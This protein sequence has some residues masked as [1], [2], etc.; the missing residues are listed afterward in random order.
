VNLSLSRIT[1]RDTL[2]ERGDEQTS[3]TGRPADLDIEQRVLAV[4]LTVYG[5]VGWAGFTLDRV[6]R[7]LRG[8]PAG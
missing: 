1:R 6:A 4:A 5:E 7:R 3:Y 8:V 2:G